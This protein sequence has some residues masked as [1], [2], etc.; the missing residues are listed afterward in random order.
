MTH[1]FDTQIAEIVGIEGAIILNYL[2]FWIQKNKANDRNFYEGHYWTYNSYKAWKELFPYM[3]ENTIKRVLRNLKELGL[4]EV[5]Q[6]NKQ[7]YDKTN[8][9]RLTEKYYS[10]VDKS[11]SSMVKKITIEDEKNNNLSS[12]K[13]QCN[14]IHLVTT[15][16]NKHLATSFINIEEQKKSENDFEDLQP[17]SDKVLENNYTLQVLL[18]ELNISLSDVKKLIAYRKVLKKPLKTMRGLIGLL[19]AIKN[20]SK[21]TGKSFDEIFEIMMENEWQSIKPEYLIK[22]DTKT[23]EKETYFDEELG[24]EVR[25]GANWSDEDFEF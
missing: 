23:K 2:D 14:N 4:I 9:Y 12:E 1:C 24:V 19:R 21:A 7:N 25:K 6:L 15:D 18:K 17:L 22:K 16:S 10:M 11:N 20:T 8:Y 5:K 3:K 13:Q